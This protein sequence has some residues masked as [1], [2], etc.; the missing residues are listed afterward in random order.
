MLDG[1]VIAVAVQFCDRRHQSTGHERSVRVGGSPKPQAG[2]LGPGTRQP[3]RV[4]R[5]ATGIPVIF[6]STR[7]GSHMGFRPLARLAASH[8][9]RRE[10]LM[11]A[12]RVRSPFCRPAP[13]IARITS[14]ADAR[15]TIKRGGGTTGSILRDVAAA[16]TA[17]EQ[18]T[19]PG[20]G[21]A[22]PDRG[23]PARRSRASHA[24]APGQI[25]HG[26]AKVIM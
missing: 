2:A 4:E 26:P 15:R 23:P 1:R 12:R 14:L 16:A 17:A 3:S 18:A 10:R 19:G 8:G 9:H 20:A 11:P 5:I 25:P 21:A 22:G 24:E 13:L 6:Q 7:S